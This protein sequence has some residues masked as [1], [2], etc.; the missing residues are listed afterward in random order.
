VQGVNKSLIRFG[1]PYW[2]FG[3]AGDRNAG[4]ISL[5]AALARLV[6]TPFFRRGTLSFS[7]R[8]M[9]RDMRARWSGHGNGSAGG[10]P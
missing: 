5:A 7:C 10:S 4:L 8:D 1:K 3:S 2:L 6:K 9:L